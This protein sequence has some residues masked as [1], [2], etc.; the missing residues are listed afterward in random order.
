MQFQLCY[1]LS[2]FLFTCKNSNKKSYRKFFKASERTV[3]T[4]QPDRN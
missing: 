4:R 3:G 2:T 1:Y